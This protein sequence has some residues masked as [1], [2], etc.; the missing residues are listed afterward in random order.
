[1][2]NVTR[3]VGTLEVIERLPSSPHGNPRWLV[4]I[5][6]WTCRTAPDSSIAYSIT[7]HSGKR[8]VAH[9]GTYYGKATVRDVR[10]VTTED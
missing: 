2:K 5:D 6:G 4:R 9:I 1:M 8:V 10:R 3:H 7:N